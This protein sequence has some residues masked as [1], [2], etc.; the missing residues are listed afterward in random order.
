MNGFQ[1]RGNGLSNQ[2]NRKTTAKK[3]AKSTVGNSNPPEVSGGGRDYSVRKRARASA[4]SRAR[5][6]KRAADDADSWE[7][8]AYWLTE[9][10]RSL[11]ALTTC[12]EA[13]RCWAV[14]MEISL[15]AELVFWAT[16]VMRSSDRPASLTSSTPADASRLPSSVALMVAWVSLWISPTRS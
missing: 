7:P 5:A 15:A 13:E 1:R 3:R 9:P 6:E 12:S 2:L 16:S 10:E 4:S 14:A 11:M 8:D